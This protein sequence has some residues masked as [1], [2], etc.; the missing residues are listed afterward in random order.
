MSF[1]GPLGAIAGVAGGFAQGAGAMQQAR[2]GAASSNYQAVVAANN[3]RSRMK[4]PTERSHPARKRP[5]KSV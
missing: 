4:R 3:A 1:L 5:R 2:A